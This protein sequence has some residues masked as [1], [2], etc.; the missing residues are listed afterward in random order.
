MENVTIGNGCSELPN[1]IFSGCSVLS[2]V[3]LSDGLATIS[4]AV[5]ANCKSLES[6][7]I[8]GTVLQIGQNTGVSDLPFYNCTSL[9][10][11]RFEDGVQNLVL[12][13]YYTDSG[14]SSSE[15]IGLFSY[16]PLEEVYIG[17]NIT[18][19]DGSYPFE[20]YQKKYGYS[21]FYNQ[22]KLAKVTISSTVTEIPAY[23]FRSCSVLSNV[24]I[25]GQLSKIPAYSFDGCKITEL[26][27]SNSI[28][29][30]GD[31]AFQ[32][33]T[34]LTTAVLG[35]NVKTIGKYAFSGCSNLASLNLGK[36]LV[37]IG[38]YSFQSVGSKSGVG[39]ILS[40]PSTLSSIGKY[41]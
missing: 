16:C 29:N 1:S 30:I 14:Y 17:R 37:S 2:S 12:G 23:L 28:E 27:L 38:D 4:D 41:I 39:L 33:N 22:P 24:S 5:F 15:G 21:A 7:S 3:F 35:N 26:T 36:S 8:P 34:A 31:Y 6:I 18:Y 20:N 13:S 19:I 32:N 25:L 9:K 40:V 10:S 11:V